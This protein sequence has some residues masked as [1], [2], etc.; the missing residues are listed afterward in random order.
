MEHQE[1]DDITYTLLARFFEGEATDEETRSISSWKT[2]SEANA[3]LFAK[4]KLIWLESDTAHFEANN[5]TDFNADAA[6]NKVERKIAKPQTSIRKLPLFMR[7]AA[8]VAVCMTVGYLVFTQFNSPNQLVEVNTSDKAQE[9]VLKDGSE[10]EL[11]QSSTLV[12]SDNQKRKTRE[13]ELKGEAFFNITKDSLRPFIIHTQELDIKVLG[14]SFNVDAK[15]QDSVEVQVETGVV[16]LG[17]KNQKIKLVAGETGVFYQGLGKLIKRE[18]RVVVSQ[19]WRN[20]KLTFKRT[21]LIEIV[22]TLN[23]LYEVNIRVD[24]STEQHRKINVRFEDQDIDLILDILS[25]TLNLKI[26]KADNGEIILYNA[27]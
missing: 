11:N 23:R 9:I 12:Y 13:V 25:S 26:E 19:F 6:W 2:Q 15:T 22:E 3:D 14:T 16:E 5:V 27:D 8:I 18:S 1:F 17:Y 24:E 21:E 7:V 10:V 20:R 4:A